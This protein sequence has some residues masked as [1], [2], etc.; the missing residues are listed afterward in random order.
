MRI[1]VRPMI[2]DLIHN[3]LFDYSYLTIYCIVFAYFFMLYFVLAPIFK[4][5]CAYLQKINILEIINSKP[6][7]K[8]QIKSEKKNSFVSLLVFGFSAIPIIYLV[9][10]G[11]IELPKSTVSNTI[12]GLVILNLW[13]EI[14]FYIV[15][16]LMHIPFFMKRVHVTHHKSVVPTVYSVFSFHWF[17]ATMLSTVPLTAIFILP[18]DPLA[19]F[20]YPATSILLNYAGHCNY[21]RTK[22]LP[23]LNFATRHSAHHKKGRDNIGF[24]L[25][26]FDKIF[27]PKK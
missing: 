14:H 21:R 1:R 5:S 3:I 19:I 15:H 10:N 24:A 6:L 7:R 27:S 12:I 4:S 13:N 25:N 11:I 23:I 17:E 9:R 26:I 16:R 2:E 22:K 18:I 8:N 20:L